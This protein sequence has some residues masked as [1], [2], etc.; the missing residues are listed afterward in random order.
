METNKLLKVLIISN[1]FTALFAIGACY[2]S[3]RA[4][5]DAESAY[6]EAAH[7]SSEA[8][9]AAASA[10]DAARAASNAETS[11]SQAEHEASTANSAISKIDVYGVSC[12]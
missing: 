10:A 8:S 3:Y 6:Y 4:S 9:D 12:N 1:F 2:F 11:A 7:A 5:G